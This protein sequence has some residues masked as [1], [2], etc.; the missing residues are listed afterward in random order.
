MPGHCG[1]V[2]QYH[3]GD[4]GGV[5]DGGCGGEGPWG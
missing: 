5:G 1:R 2:V 3:G 4:N